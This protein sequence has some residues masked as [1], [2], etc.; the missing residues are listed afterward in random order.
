MVR[1]CTALL[2]ACALALTCAPP[3]PAQAQTSAAPKP[4]AQPTP[5]AAQPQQPP[6]LDKQSEKIMRVVRKAGVGGRLTVFLNNGEE[7]H[8]AVSQIGADSFAL[9]EVDRHDLFTILYRDVRKVRTG[10]DG[11]NL[12]TGRRVSRSRGVKFASF[13]IVLFTAVG[14]PLIL[15]AASKD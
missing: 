13:A 1:T 5:A 6:A 15:V 14:L 12:F 8:G 3:A 4:A 7:L 2:L 11:I 10:Y 9:A